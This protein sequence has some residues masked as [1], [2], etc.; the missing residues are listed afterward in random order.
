MP[1]IKGGRSAIG[2]AALTL[3]PVGPAIAQSTNSDD[4]GDGSTASYPDKNIGV[5]GLE[6]TATRFP[7]DK[8]TNHQGDLPFSVRSCGGFLGWTCNNAISYRVRI[9][10]DSDSGNYLLSGQETGNGLPIS[11]TYTSGGISDQPLPGSWSS[12]IFSG[13]AQG[14][15]SPASLAVLIPNIDPGTLPDTYSG[16]FLFSIDQEPCSGFWCLS[17]YLEPIEFRI[18]IEVERLIRIS[19]LGDMV[20]TANPTGV[21]EA[22]QT[23]CVYSQGGLPF[24][25]AA[26][27][28]NGSG[29][30]R[31]TGIDTI[32]YETWIG[33]LASGSL[34]QLLEGQESAQSWPGRLHENCTV[35][36]DN[37]EISIRIQPVAFGNAM[38]TSYTD[39]LT[40]TVILD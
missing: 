18:N 15:Q 31:L 33:S 37:M 11:L 10:G 13:G 34:E 19:A 21:T 8:G 23:F 25:I 26:D 22:G 2:V 24:S 27:S 7:Y 38:G 29:S 5:C 16:D 3:L 30:F 14:V 17:T 4:C 9:D 36:G 35:A 6:G 1:F 40:L 32:E 28:D 20:I 39:T 12:A